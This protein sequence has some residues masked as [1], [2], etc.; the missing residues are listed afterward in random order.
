[1]HLSSLTSYFVANSSMKFGK[2][3]AL[4]IAGTLTFAACKYEE[5]PRISLRNKRDRVANEWKIEEFSMGDVD[6]KNRLEFTGDTTID[7]KKYVYHFATILSFFRTGGYSLEVCQVVTDANGN[8]EYL[9]NHEVNFDKLPGG[10]Q[11][12]YGHMVDSF[13][14]PFKYIRPGGKW[15]FDKGHYK[16]QVKPDLSFVNDETGNAKNTLDWTIV[17]LA[18][19]EM[20]LKGLDEN[21]NPWKMRLKAINK[22][23]YFY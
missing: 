19:K 16:I 5:G 3:T 6:M 11:I 10:H 18:Q 17:K 7:G 21:N 8:E 20:K 12:V 2:L 1:M 22:E 4:A 23:P 13:P 9:T 15:S 14:A